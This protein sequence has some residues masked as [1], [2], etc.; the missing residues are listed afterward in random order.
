MR[1][2]SGKKQ[3]PANTSRRANPNVATEAAL[4]VRRERDSAMRGARCAAGLA[5]ARR[6]DRR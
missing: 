1:R 2:I 3:E 6:Y 5:H 4:A